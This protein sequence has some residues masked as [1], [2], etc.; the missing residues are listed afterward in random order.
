VTTNVV[1]LFGSP[2]FASLQDGLLAIARKHSSARTD[3]IDL[4]KSIDG[5]TAAGRAAPLIECEAIDAA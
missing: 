1:N 4:L 2:A 5:G 3:I